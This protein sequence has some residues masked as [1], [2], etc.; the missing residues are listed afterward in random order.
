MEEAL[1]ARLLATAAISA[2]YGNRIWPQTRPADVNSLPAATITVASDAREYSHDGPDDV[3]EARIQIDSRGRTYSEAKRGLRL[4]LSELET[5]E[6][7]NGVQFDMGRKVS[8]NDAPKEVLG[9]GTEI[10]RV[11]M[12]VAI[13]FRVT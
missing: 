5:E 12:D 11:T 8:G 6:T 2:H 4:I 9:G 1:I 3:Q 7:V 13:F 10:F